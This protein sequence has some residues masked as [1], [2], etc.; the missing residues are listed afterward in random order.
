M[1]VFALRRKSLRLLVIG[2]SLLVFGGFLTGGPFAGSTETLAGFVTGIKKLHPIYSVDTKEPK[3][4]ISFDASWGAERT[5][6]ILDILDKY[7]VKTTFFLVNIWLKEYPDKAQEIVK[8]GHEI[9]LHSTTHPDF[10]KLSEQ[11][12]EKELTANSEMIYKLTK[13]KPILFRPPFGSYNNTVITVAQRLGYHV[14]QWDVD[15]LDWKNLSAN[16]IQ[17]RV[18][19]KVKNGS[20]V[21]FHNDGKYTPEALGP[22]IAELQKKGFK[23]VPVSELIYQNDYY[24]DVN[25]I[26]HSSQ[27]PKN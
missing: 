16:E 21:L 27:A 24:V 4:A 15:S 23:I 2:I 25:G 19:K 1:R 3:V 13:F 12:M 14:I 5:P 9:G 8:R 20:I 17:N 11:Q 7:K 22:I 10:K 6:K 26:Q 18:L